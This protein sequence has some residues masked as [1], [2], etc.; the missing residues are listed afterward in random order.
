MS[1]DFGL[2]PKEGHS[3]KQFT[4]AARNVV[5]YSERLARAE[6]SPYIDTA[7]IRTAAQKVIAGEKVDNL[8]AK[9]SGHI[10]FTVEAKKVFEQSLRICLAAEAPEITPEHLLEATAS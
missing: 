6:G 3:S 4:N 5:V 7:H 1:I 10:S 8:T 2:V 9:V